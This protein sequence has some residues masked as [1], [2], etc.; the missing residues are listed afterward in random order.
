MKSLQEIKVAELFHSQLDDIERLRSD[1][2][3][4]TIAKNAATSS[5]NQASDEYAVAKITMQTYV[6]QLG[7]I[8]L[9]SEDKERLFK[10]LSNWYGNAIII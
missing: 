1:I 7:T 5:L 9:A 3:R 6:R 2:D 10:L 4:F 8:H